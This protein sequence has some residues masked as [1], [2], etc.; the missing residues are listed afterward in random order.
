MS[1]IQTRFDMEMY[2]ANLWTLV[3][4]NVLLPALKPRHE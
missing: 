2:S 4:W 3:G 1:W